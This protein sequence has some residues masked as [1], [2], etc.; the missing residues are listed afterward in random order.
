MPICGRRAGP[1]PVRLAGRREG[2]AQL[3]EAAQARS[4]SFAPPS[5]RLFACAVA[6]AGDDALA[7]GL[8]SIVGGTSS[9]NV[10]SEG[11]A[12]RAC[13]AAG[14]LRAGNQEAARARMAQFASEALRLR[15]LLTNDPGWA[16]EEISVGYAADLLA[17][18]GGSRR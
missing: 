5:G 11:L 6:L 10:M 12:V 16:Q 3:L 7:E 17:T 18:V 4:G 8:R 1:L 15:Q 14:L 9:G 2:L 13:Q